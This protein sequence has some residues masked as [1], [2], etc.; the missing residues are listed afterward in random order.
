M[1]FFVRVRS[2]D[3]DVVFLASRRKCERAGRAVVIINNSSLLCLVL[4]HALD[5]L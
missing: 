2:V 4:L 5:Q 1:S 3:R